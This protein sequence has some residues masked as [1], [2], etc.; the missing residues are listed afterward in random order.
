MWLSMV[1]PPFSIEREPLSPPACPSVYRRAS[2]S[3]NPHEYFNTKVEK[4]LVRFTVDTALDVENASFNILVLREDG[5]TFRE[6][7]PIAKLRAFRKFP[8]RLGEFIMFV[9]AEESDALQ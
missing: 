7:I 9:M 4:N 6:S 2:C 5:A 8:L 3:H 1:L